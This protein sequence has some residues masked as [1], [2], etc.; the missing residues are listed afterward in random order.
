[1]PA[2][3]VIFD[4]RWDA[5]MNGVLGH[6]VCHMVENGVNDDLDSVLVCDLAHCLEV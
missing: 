5:W 2:T 4:F 6:I 3:A 1:M